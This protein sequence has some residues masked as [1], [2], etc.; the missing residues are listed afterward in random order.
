MMSRAEV[1]QLSEK[2]EAAALRERQQ[3]AML[4]YRGQRA[5]ETGKKM[6][7]VAL[8]G[9]VGVAIVER[10]TDGREKETGVSQA[11]AASK[12]RRSLLVRAGMLAVAV[13]RWS[14]VLSRAWLSLMTRQAKMARVPA[15]APPASDA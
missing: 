6:A 15:D 9:L 2:A 5:V 11:G 14:S 1:R 8:A 13:M 10:L 7:L 4:S 12:P 3:R